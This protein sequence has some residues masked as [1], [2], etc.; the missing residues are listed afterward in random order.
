MNLPVIKEMILG[1]FRERTRRYSFL[2]TLLG[3]MFFGYL[4]ITDQYTVRFSEY[5]GE[6]NGAWEGTLMAVSC[7]IMLTIFG[8]YLVKNA[9]RRDRLTN[10]G[11]TL[12]AGCPERCYWSIW[13]WFEC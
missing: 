10:V 4:V 5:R 3:T 11:Q 6:Y 9:I 2:L 7:S 8:F 13:S 12:A 1:D